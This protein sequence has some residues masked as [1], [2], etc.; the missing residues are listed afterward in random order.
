MAMWNFAIK[1]FTLYIGKYQ[2]DIVYGNY[3]ILWAGIWF[4]YFGKIELLNEEP[5]NQDQGFPS[6]F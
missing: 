5:C 3:C 2:N 6:H 1:A 4:I